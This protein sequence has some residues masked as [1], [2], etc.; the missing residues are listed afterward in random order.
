MPL[1][2]T[3]AALLLVIG[4]SAAWALAATV[5]GMVEVG[6]RPWPTPTAVYAP[7]AVSS[8]DLCPTTQRSSDRCQ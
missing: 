2:I 4:Y 5:A 8:A 3:L 6:R 7:T 1:R